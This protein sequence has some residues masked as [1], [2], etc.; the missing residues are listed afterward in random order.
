MGDRKWFATLKAAW[1]RL[2]RR[3]EFVR[4]DRSWL[5]DRCRHDI[6]LTEHETRL[7][8]DWIEQIRHKHT[9]LW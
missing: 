9:R 7:P 3:R 8:S 4:L 2:S 1:R 5:A 6:G